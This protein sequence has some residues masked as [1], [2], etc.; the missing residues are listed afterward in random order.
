MLEDP[1]G[2]CEST[3][4]SKDEHKGRTDTKSGPE[5]EHYFECSKHYPKSTEEGKSEHTSSVLYRAGDESNGG[6]SPTNLIDDE[7]TSK[8]HA[9]LLTEV[10]C[11]GHHKHTVYFDRSN[12]IGSDDVPCCYTIRSPEHPKENNS[13]TE[14]NRSG[15]SINRY[16]ILTCPPNSVK[17]TGTIDITYGADVYNLEYSSNHVVPEKVEET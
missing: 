13:L 5:S 6:Y 10:S 17:E 3:S 11:M 14:S 9:D 8:R 16:H 15:T 2:H 7:E 4:L 1:E 12:P